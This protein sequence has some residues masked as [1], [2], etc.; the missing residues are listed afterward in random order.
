MFKSIKEFFFGKPV[1]VEAKYKVEAPTIVALGEP[2]ATVVV[3]E[4]AGKVEVPAQS[5]DSMCCGIEGCTHDTAPAKK[6]PAKK[7]AAKKPAA[8]KAPA[9]KGGRKPKASK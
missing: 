6:A 9:K 4:G 3:V 7:P 1:E 5:A 8:A 2:P